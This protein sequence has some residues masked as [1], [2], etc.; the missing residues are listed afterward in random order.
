MWPL[1]YLLLCT[2]G[3]LDDLM[4]LYFLILARKANL[5]HCKYSPVTEN[6]NIP[7]VE[8]KEAFLSFNWA[9]GL[10]KAAW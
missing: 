8:A 1:P 2:V 6:T 5:A 9:S 7:G 3:Q 10:S 4:P